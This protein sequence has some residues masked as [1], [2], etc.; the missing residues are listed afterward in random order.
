MKAAKAITRWRPEIYSHA[1]DGAALSA[2]TIDAL[3][4]TIRARNMSI[5][6]LI[7]SFVNAVHSDS[8]CFWGKKREEKKSMSQFVVQH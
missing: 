5:S 7:K 6:P 4:C 1:C 8:N 3:L 2:A